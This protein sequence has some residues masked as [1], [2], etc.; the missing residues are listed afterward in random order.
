MMWTEQRAI[1]ESFTEGRKFHIS[2]P[3]LPFVE[4]VLLSSGLCSGGKIGQF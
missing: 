2:T 1:F 4:F 3:E